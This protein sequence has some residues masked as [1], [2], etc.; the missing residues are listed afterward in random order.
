MVFFYQVWTNILYG[1]TVESWNMG[2]PHISAENEAWG[3]KKIPEK[4]SLEKM[5]NC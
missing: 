2:V 4:M 3:I 1:M 5:S